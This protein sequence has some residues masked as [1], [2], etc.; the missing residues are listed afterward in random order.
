MDPIGYWA[1]P[2]G[3]EPISEMTR[4]RLLEV[5]KFLGA[6][7]QDTERRHDQHVKEL[8]A[9]GRPSPFRIWDDPISGLAYSI[10]TTAAMSRPYGAEMDQDD[11]QLPKDTDPP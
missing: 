4:E 11:A 1:G 2:N 5:V 7:A 10:P 3:I 9:L 6:G 8:E